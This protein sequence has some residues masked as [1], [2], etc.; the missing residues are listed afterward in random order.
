[1][2]HR[3][4][5]IPAEQSSIVMSSADG[6]VED[7]SDNGMGFNSVTIRHDGFA[8]LYGHVESFLVGAG[9]TV[10]KG[11]AIALSGGRPGTPGAGHLS[12]GPHLHF[13]IIKD[14]VRVDPM[15]YLPEAPAD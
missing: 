13:E 10:R 6:V 12:T 14:G 2:P 7:V 1:M 15:E 3:A 4:I 9:D 8:T 5:D 11:Q